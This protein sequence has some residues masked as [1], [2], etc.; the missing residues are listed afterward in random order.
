MNVRPTHGDPRQLKKRFVN[1]QKTTPVGSGSH[2]EVGVHKNR[3]YDAT[4]VS[5][6]KSGRLDGD[7][8]YNFIKELA[9]DDSMASNPYFPRVYNLNAY[10]N[11]ESDSFVARMEK[12]IPMSDLNVKQVDAI[13]RRIVD[14][15]VEDSFP[16]IKQMGDEER[17]NHLI[18]QVLN[19]IRGRRTHAVPKDTHFNQAL[20]KINMLKQDHRGHIDWS[21]DNMMARRTPHGAQLVFSD[22][23]Y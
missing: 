16:E 20:D 4:K 2:A 14:R 21:V 12:L 19:M 23:L 22:P 10:T 17:K 11:D 6:P 7:G 18:Q 5:V 8:F 9:K 3:P 1:N 13:L 15:D